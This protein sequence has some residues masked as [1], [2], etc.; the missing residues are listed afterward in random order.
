MD[1]ANQS[2][3]PRSHYYILPDTVFC[4]FLPAA[5]TCRPTEFSCQDR[6]NQ[7]VP[8]TWRCDGKADCENGADEEA[9]GESELRPTCHSSFPL[10]CPWSVITLIALSHVTLLAPKQ[11]TDNEFHC[12]NG[13]C[14][15]SSFVCDDDADC[16]DASD[17]ANCPPITCSSTAFQCNNSAC[18]PRLWA[19]DGDTDCTD[20][21]D[22]WPQNCGAKTPTAAPQ[23]CHSL[24]FRC[25]SGECIHG[26]WKCDGGADCVDRSDEADCGTDHYRS[27]PL[28][29]R[30]KYHLFVLTPN[31]CLLGPSSSSHLSSWWVWMWWWHLYPRQPSVQPTV[32]LQGHEWWN[33]LCQWYESASLNQ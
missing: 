2:I 29:I 16:D 3:R 9:C 13:Q 33:W 4:V 30:C 11:C 23:Q 10:M 17:E 32:R 14:V 19:C 8:N 25:G 15:S 1:L 28:L 5:K 12:R 21:S 20:G 22:E 6:L 7:C 31:I 27:P 24:E 26:S 18:V